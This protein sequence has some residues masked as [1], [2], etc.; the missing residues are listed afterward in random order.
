MIRIQLVPGLRGRDRTAV[1]WNHCGLVVSSAH[2]VARELIAAT[3][4]DQ[5]WQAIERDEPERNGDNGFTAQ[6]CIG[7]RWTITEGDGP[8]RF[9]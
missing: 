9:P 7:S 5:A 8:V 2:G 3:C 4:A 6:A 1:I